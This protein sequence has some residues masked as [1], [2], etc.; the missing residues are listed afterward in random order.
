MKLLSEKVLI[1]TRSLLCGAVLI[2]AFAAA[3][4]QG[5]GRT[6]TRRRC[7]QTS[8]RSNHLRRSLVSWLPSPLP[9]RRSAASVGPSRGAM[10]MTGRSS[11]SS[12]PL[13]PATPRQHRAGCPPERIMRARR[14]LGL[15]RG[16]RAGP[17]HPADARDSDTWGV[18][19]LHDQQH[20]EHLHDHRHRPRVAPWARV[21][22]AGQAV[23]RRV[24][25]VTRV[26][27]EGV[28]A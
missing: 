6:T 20:L 13:R 28:T 8:S 18:S 19:P 21:L 11:T 16:R 25:A 2:V 27:S 3:E 17:G 15:R 23:D 22:G 7:G 24:A 26:S 4:A 14:G 12:P 1:M 10:G 5:P 9:K